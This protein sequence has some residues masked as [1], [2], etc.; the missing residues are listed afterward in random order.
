ML[1]HV[2]LQGNLRVGVAGLHQVEFVPP[3]VGVVIDPGLVVQ[4]LRQR[5]FDDRIEIRGKDFDTETLRSVA[6][7][8]LRISGGGKLKD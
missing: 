7:T 5:I 6:K 8:S 3:P 4:R 1:Q 2:S